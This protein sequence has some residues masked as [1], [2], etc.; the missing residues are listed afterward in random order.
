M[1]EKI[2]KVMWNK[3]ISLWC[4]VKV[5]DIEYTIIWKDKDNTNNLI[6]LNNEGLTYSL[7]KKYFDEI[8]WKPVMIWDILYYVSNNNLNKEKEVIEIWGDINED[9]SFK[10]KSTIKFIFN[11]IVD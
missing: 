9:I 1:L 11:L 2:Q 3:T 6:L 4:V 5:D 8:I 10:P 7:E